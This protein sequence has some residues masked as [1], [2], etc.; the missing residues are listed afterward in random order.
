MSGI[1]CRVCLYCQSNR[2][3]KEMAAPLPDTQVGQAF[4]RVFNGLLMLMSA[5]GKCP[6]IS[7]CPSKCLLVCVK[8][9]FLY[10]C[11]LMH[12]LFKCSPSENGKLQMNRHCWVTQRDGSFGGWR[13]ANA[14]HNYTAQFWSSKERI[15]FP[16]W[17]LWLDFLPPPS[18]ISPLLHINYLPGA[19]V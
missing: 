6:C 5:R 19:E 1:P 14:G 7:A 18:K 16:V 9:P 4:W 10:V 2:F 8:G 15:I 11:L 13:D 12:L 3:L 17:L